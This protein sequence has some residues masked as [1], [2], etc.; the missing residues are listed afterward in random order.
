MG[1]SK[2]AKAIFDEIKEAAKND[3]LCLMECEEIGTKKKVPVI[4][5]HC[6]ENGVHHFQPLAK[7]FAGNPY[8]Q[9][10]PP[11]KEAPRLI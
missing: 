9:V 7:L 8:N 6:T 10:A 1:L 4:C 11:G 5:S 3:C 2:K